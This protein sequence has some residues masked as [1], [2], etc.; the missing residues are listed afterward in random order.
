MKLTR[1]AIPARYEW[2]RRDPDYD[3]L[4]EL[5]DP[6]FWLGAVVCF[7]GFLAFCVLMIVTLG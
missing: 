4:E 1:G 3:D 6:R 2:D 7:F 5:R